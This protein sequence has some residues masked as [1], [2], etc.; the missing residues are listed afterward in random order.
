M[1]QTVSCRI[2]FSLFEKELDNIKTIK[3]TEGAYFSDKDIPKEPILT[4]FIWKPELRPT[5]KADVI[6]G[7]TTE[8]PKT[9]A[10]PATTAPVKT[11][12]SKKPVV[13]K[14]GANTS[15]PETKKPIVQKN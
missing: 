13:P 15:K 3:D 9:A 4:G 12:S 5:S 1:N 11:T 10:K 14:K 6:K 8:K 2:K 7:K